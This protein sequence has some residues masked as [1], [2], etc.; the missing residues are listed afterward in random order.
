MLRSYIFTLRTFHDPCIDNSCPAMKLVLIRH[1]SVEVAKGVCY[2]QSDVPLADSFIEEAEIIKDY[3]KRYEFSDVFSS[4]LSRCLRLAEYCGFPDAIRD[5]RLM[6]MNFGEWE[7][8]KF[9]EITDP[10]LDEWY[11]DY[12]NVAPTGGESS[13]MQLKRFK[14]FSDSLIRSHTPGPVAVFTHG[15]I[16]IHALVEFSGHTYEEAFSLSSRY[17]T[18]IEIEL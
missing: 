11:A 2:G 4:P 1:T 8:Q 15:G 17:G 10:R 12:L 9:D 3:L 6:E 16:L 5:N 18:I 13:V 14:D 7:M